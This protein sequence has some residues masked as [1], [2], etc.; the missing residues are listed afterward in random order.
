MPFDDSDD[1]AAMLE[2]TELGHTAV[3]T[4]P[5]GDALVLERCHFDLD[6]YEAGLDQA[7]VD[8]GQPSILCRAQDLGDALPEEGWLASVPDEGNFK[9]LYTKGPKDD[10]VRIVLHEI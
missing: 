9:V 10:L 4:P 1:L 2:P 3:L 6:F 8:T 5:S 7:P